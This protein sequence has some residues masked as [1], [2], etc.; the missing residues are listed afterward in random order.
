MTRLTSF[1]RNFSSIELHHPQS[2][3]MS[4]EQHQLPI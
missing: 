3:Q 2:L 4:H 1:D